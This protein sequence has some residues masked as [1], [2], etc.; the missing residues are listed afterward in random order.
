MNDWNVEVGRRRRRTVALSPSFRRM[1]VSRKAFVDQG[2]DLLSPKAKRFVLRLGIR[3]QGL[4]NWSWSWLR[5]ASHIR[6]V[7]TSHLDLESADGEYLSEVFQGGRC[8]NEWECAHDGVAFFF[9]DSSIF[10]RPAR[11]NGKSLY[12]A[13][14]EMAT[15]RVHQILKRDTSSFAGSPPGS[16]NSCSYSIE[17]PRWQN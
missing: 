6:I 4:Q 8:G 16:T 9:V 11:A 5:Q 1:C 13:G 7:S 17:R 15:C 2:Q 12:A 14:C 3:Q 10:A